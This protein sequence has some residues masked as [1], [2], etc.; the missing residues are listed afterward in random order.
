MYN[1]I[2]DVHYWV[3]ECKSQV[4]MIQCYP[5]QYNSRNDRFLW[6]PLCKILQFYRK[7]SLIPPH[8]IVFLSHLIV[9]SSKQR[10]E[11]NLYLN[12]KDNLSDQNILLFC[13]SLKIQFLCRHVRWISYSCYSHHW[14][15]YKQL[16]LFWWLETYPTPHHSQ[17]CY[18]TIIQSNKLY[19]GMIHLLIHLTLVFILFTSNGMFQVKRKPFFGFCT[20][21]P[22]Q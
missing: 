19:F 2:T 7:L 14:I 9:R 22:N 10:N 18:L 3:L 6:A 12:V 8:K 11:I 4:Y 5:F 1:L 17:Y 16:C 20:F 15:Q 13:W 21:W